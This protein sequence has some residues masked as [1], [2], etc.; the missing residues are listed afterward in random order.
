MDRRSYLKTGLAAGGIATLAG[1]AGFG[2]LGDTDEE[3]DDDDG[4]DDAGADDSETDDEPDD[5]H[6]PDDDL[7]GTFD[8]FEDLDQWEAFQ[9]IG[10]VEADTDR[11]AE[12]SQSARLY[13]DD[14]GQV[15]FRRSLEEPIDIRGVVPG[16]AMCADVRSEVLIQ[17]QDEDGDYLEFSQQVMDNETPV[18]CNF[19]L[20][21]IRGDPDLSEIIVL[22]VIHWAD[23]EADPDESRLWIDDF[24]FVP[25]TDTG[26]VMLQFHGGYEGHYTEALPILEEYGLT[27]TV[28]VP[29]DRIRSDR[30]VDGDRLTENQVDQLGDADWTIAAHSANGGRLEDVDSP[31]DDL[32]SNVT[33]PID[34]LEDR[35][36]DDGARFFAFP[37][38][39]YSDGSYEVVQDNYD[40]AFAGN[41]PA[42]GYAGNPHLCSTTSTPDPGEVQDVLEW[43]AEHGGITT[44]PFYALEED[45]AI[46]A[47]EETASTLADLEGEGELE[48]ITP[49][50]MADEYVY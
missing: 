23:E 27:G 43:T 19:G 35:G 48:V 6:E 7:L 39:E 9:D 49:A 2:D 4:T 31:T 36:Y 22:Q 12:G 38:G 41:A 24:H 17:L 8:D 29:T 33:D 32:E 20:T 37:G 34:W 13:P 14:D 30:A 5:E 47:L 10:S 42:Q 45:D 25:N 15:R 44:I 50:E 21:R 1:C 46:T 3:R 26:T 18:R 11:Y 28:F 40:L 16:I